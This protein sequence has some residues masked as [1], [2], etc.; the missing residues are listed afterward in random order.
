[1]GGVKDWVQD[2]LSIAGSPNDNLPNKILLP[3][4]KG[5]DSG[6]CRLGIFLINKVSDTDIHI[7]VDI[8][9]FYGIIDF[10][11]ALKP[12]Y[13]LCITS[14]RI[15]IKDRS[16]VSRARLSKADRHEAPWRI[17]FNILRLR[18]GKLMSVIAYSVQHAEQRPS[19]LKF[20]SASTWQKKH[21]SR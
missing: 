6:P 11:I 21:P 14:P 12:P 15:L 5:T 8:D 1:M 16:R 17:D 10:A 9:V 13:H 4:T 20:I 19:L 2:F 3:V 7:D 18:Y